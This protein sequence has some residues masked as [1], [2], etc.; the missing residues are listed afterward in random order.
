MSAKAG[1]RRA[2]QPAILAM[3]FLRDVGITAGHQLFQNFSFTLA[4][5]EEPSGKLLPQERRLKGVR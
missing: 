1:S 4:G 2:D 3:L 5:G